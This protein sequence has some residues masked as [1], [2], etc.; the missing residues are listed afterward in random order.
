MNSLTE[1]A[2]VW[3]L[4]CEGIP[5]THIAEKLEMVGPPSTVG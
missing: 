5:K 3:E 1:I 2:I 4:H